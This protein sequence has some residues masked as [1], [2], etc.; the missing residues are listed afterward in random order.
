LGKIGSRYFAGGGVAL[1]AGV[2]SCAPENGET[3]VFVVVLP[4]V[5]PVPGINGSAP[6]KGEGLAGGEA[7]GLGVAV[8]LAGVSGVAL[9]KGEEVLLPDALAGVRGLAPARG[10]EFADGVRGCAPDKVEALAG[11]FSGLA[12]AK[13][14]GAGDK[15]SD[16]NDGGAAGTGGT[17]V[18]AAGV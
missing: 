9:A 13:G 18:G 2:S 10:D 1:G 14:D 11:E 6:A 12:P 7:A 3:V 17:G 15:S 16:G 4:V 5:L 8:V